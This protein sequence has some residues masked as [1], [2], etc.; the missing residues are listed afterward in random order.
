VSRAATPVVKRDAAHGGIAK[1]APLVGWSRSEVWTYIRE[2]RLPA[3]P[4]YS[5][6]YTSIG[7]AP[8]TRA[9]RPGEDERAGR[10]YWE[11]GGVRECGLH[12]DGERPL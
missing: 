8:C 11:V 9:T 1:I 7:C 12:W 5:E 2:H 4:L 10:W 3:H 6:G